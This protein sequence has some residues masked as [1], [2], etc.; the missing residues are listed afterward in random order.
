MLN[1]AANVSGKMKTAIPTIQIAITICETDICN[2]GE[3]ELKASTSV[4]NSFSGTFALW[5]SE[6]LIEATRD[7]VPGATSPESSTGSDADLD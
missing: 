3:V 2:A 1:R 5:L 4:S 6:R 7:F